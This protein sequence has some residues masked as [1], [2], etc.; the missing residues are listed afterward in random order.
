MVEQGLC[1]PTL[2]ETGMLGS[3]HIHA[4]KDCGLLQLCPSAW[5][6]TLIHVVHP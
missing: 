5:A 3:I 1:F 4:D 2:L 6:V